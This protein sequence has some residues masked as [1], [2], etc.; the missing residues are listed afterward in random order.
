MNAAGMVV[1]E[2]SRVPQPALVKQGV[3]KSFFQ[4]QSCVST[5]ANTSPQM[6]ARFMNKTI[7]QRLAS[8]LSYV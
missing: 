7:N 3:L 6:D 1:A 5:A 4:R 8:R 2:E